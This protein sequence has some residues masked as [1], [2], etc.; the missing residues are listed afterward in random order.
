MLPSAQQRGYRPG[1]AA[2]RVV[3]S[4]KISSTR[5]FDWR[6]PASSLLAMGKFSPLPS[7][8]I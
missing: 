2:I 4:V 7:D 8:V 1:S 3:P 5:R 6:P